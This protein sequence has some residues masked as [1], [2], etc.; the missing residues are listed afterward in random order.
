MFLQAHTVFAQGARSVSEIATKHSVISALVGKI[1]SFIVIPLIEALFVFTFCMFVWGV[2][3]MIQNGD[4]SEAR[5]DGRRHMIWSVI[6]MFIMIS[7]YGIVRLIA[8]TVG[9]IE[10]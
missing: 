3:K 1:M 4:D 6:G 10:I 8:N 2:F 5:L 7:A 9:G